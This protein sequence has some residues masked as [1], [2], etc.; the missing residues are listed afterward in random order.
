MSGY[1]EL[2]SRGLS[3]VPSKEKTGE[4]FEMPG[5]RV[6]K[7][8]SRTLITNF[9]EV[10]GILRRE[11]RHLMKFILKEL[12]T[13]GEYRG[14]SIEVQG[15]FTADSVNRKLEK[16]VNSY[17]KCPECG[18]HDTN[19]SRDR[20]FTIMKCEVCGARESVSKV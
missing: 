2:L 9:A 1:D 12:A 11:P 7:S 8:G 5:F 4:R 3:K 20:G 6:Q 15:V 10:A 17:V 19:L 16:Y 14:G 13:S 18:K